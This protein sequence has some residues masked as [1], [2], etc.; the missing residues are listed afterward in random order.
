L[1]YN[2]D[3]NN[4]VQTNYLADGSFFKLREVSMTY[5]MPQSLFASSKAIKGVSFGVTGRNLLT[6]RPKSNQWSD[7]EFSTGTGNAQGSASAANLPP[8]RIFGANVKI[9]F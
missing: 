9:T 7:P 2:E 8:T 1:F 4:N 5:T 3:I 6:W